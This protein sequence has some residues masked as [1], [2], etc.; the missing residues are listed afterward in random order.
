MSAWIPTIP[1]LAWEAW[2]GTDW[3]ECEVERDETRGLNSAGDIVLHVPA[4]HTSS[5]VGTKRAS[6]LRCRLLDRKGN[7]PFYDES[8]EIA[9]V[10]TFT[11]G[12]TVGA[13][14]AAIVQ[15]EQIGVSEGVPGQRFLLE[16]RP[17]VPG[18][19]PR[20]LESS[21]DTDRWETWIEVTNFANSKPASRDFS[22]DEV[23]GEVVLGPA[24]RQ[25]DGTMRYY[26]A[27]PAKGTALRMREYLTGG[28]PR[29]NVSKGTL[30]VLRRPIAYVGSVENRH[31]A[32]GGVDGE[33]I[34]NAKVRGPIVLRTGDRAVTAG[35][36]RTTRPRGGTGTGP[37]RVYPRRGGG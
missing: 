24:V 12:G 21:T 34:A 22:L 4:G 30:T 33:D 10:V 36:L 31:H 19:R 35:G 23:A 8:P 18:R 20:V 28:G 14:H 29:G 25:P 16:R 1:P 32:S 3:A 9:D 11:I 2:D 26:G 27:V 5:T 7:E 15:N 17:V 13:S 37:S 6:W